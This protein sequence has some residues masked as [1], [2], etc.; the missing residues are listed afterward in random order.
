[1]QRRKSRLKCWTRCL[2][3]SKN[4]FFF[5]LLLGVY[6]YLRTNTIYI[7]HTSTSKVHFRSFRGIIVVE[8]VEKLKQ[9]LHQR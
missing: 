7:F 1:M 9:G 2:Y 5:F 8:L 3:D 6:A 4:S